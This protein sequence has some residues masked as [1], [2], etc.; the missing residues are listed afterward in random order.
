[1]FRRSIRAALAVLVGAGL[2]SPAVLSSST[3]TAA[4]ATCALQPTLRSSTVNQGVGSYPRLVQG[5]EALVRLFVTLPA[6]ATSRDTIELLGASLTVSG[7]AGG[8]GTLVPPIGATAPTLGLTVSNDSPS[9]PLFVVPG[10]ALT[11]P[12]GAAYTATFSATLQYRAKPAGQSTFGPTQSVVLPEAGQPP[13]SR[14][15]N[16]RSNALRVLVVPMGDGTRGMAA[17]FPAAASDATQRAMQ[18]LARMLPVPTGT[19]DLTSTAPAGLRYRVLPTLLDLNALGLMRSV[20]GTTQFC[21]SGANFAPLQEQLSA[22]RQSWNAANPLAAAD[23]VV[24]VV[25]ETV[26]IGTDAGVGCDEGVAAINGTEAWFRASSGYNGAVASM[27]VMHTLGAAIGD[28]ARVDYHSTNV[29]ADE[30]DPDRAYNLLLRRFLADDRSALRLSGAG[31]TETNTVLEPNDWAHALCRLTPLANVGCVGTTVGGPAAAG[32][33]FVLTGTVDV[34]SSTGVPEADIHSWFEPGDVEQTEVPDESIY[35]LVQRTSSGTEVRRTVVPYSSDASAHA[36]HDH[37]HTSTVESVDVTVSAHTLADVFELVRDGA[38]VYRRQ[39]NSEPTVTVIPDPAVSN[40]RNWSQDASRQDR[41][42]ALS[43]DGT[44]MAW[45]DGT[46]TFVRDVARRGATSAPLAGT[47]PVWYPANG[48]LRLAYVRNGD[49]YLTNVVTGAGAPSF[50]VPVPVYVAAQQV[51]PNAGASHPTWAPITV[52]RPDRVAIRIAGDLWEVNV[53]LVPGNEPICRA[54][55]TALDGCRPLVLTSGVDEQR[56][57]WSERGVAYDAG[58]AGGVP[59][60]RIVDPQTR[61]VTDTGVA[62]TDPA[63]AGTRLV[64]SRAAT[65]TAPAG[66]FSVPAAAPTGVAPARLT[67]SPDT[68][69]TATA[70][71]DVV[72]FVR[73][74]SDDEVHLADVGN[75]SGA[76][77]IATDADGAELLEA[78]LFVVC[79]AEVVPVVVD[80]APDS[81]DGNIARFHVAYDAGPACDDASL[82]V[83]VTDGWLTATEDITG[84]FGADDEPVPSIAAPVSGEYTEWESIPVAGSANDDTDPLTYSW[85]LVHPNGTTQALGTGTTLPDVAPPAGGWPVGDYRVRLTVTD[86]THTSTAEVVITIVDDDDNDGMPNDDERCLGPGAASDPTNAF[87][88]SD[89]DGFVNVDDPQPCTSASTMTVDFEPNTLQL[90][91][92]GTPITTYLRSTTIAMT[93]VDPASVAIIR[94]GNRPVR[95][96]AQAWSV[97]RGVGTAQFSRPQVVAFLQQQGLAG[98]YVPIVISATS[99]AGVQVQGLDGSAPVTQS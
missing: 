31:W 44:L 11:S 79:G 97:S 81:V 88:D 7:G 94:I 25:W 41:A 64:F 37:E 17:D 23:R 4:A 80:I 57:S 55:A 63:W 78:D 99:T 43:P 39:R 58:V 42:P 5:K 85:S 56:P 34:S 98:T 20:N 26:A 84:P 32:S 91:S 83:R 72:G 10:S 15:V 1:M 89:R 49:V 60:I 86:G 24:G 2:V 22:F 28:H 71:G 76:T 27:E 29:E 8:A 45:S 35:E 73:A 74:G 3:T 9:N 13:I 50:T 47:D 87:V 75:G 48:V 54:E 16:A 67:S 36:G 46:S 21:G 40:V 68:A 38:V 53:D 6:C 65:A 90:T 92:S 51:I 62:G 70:G 14:A 69:P 95:I 52:G 96:P 30:T 18:N 77:I 93:D 82:R 19:S 61:Q 33:S 66:L 12:T 59:T